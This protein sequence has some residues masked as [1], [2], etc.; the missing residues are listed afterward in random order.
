MANK[1]KLY[2]WWWSKNEQQIYE[3][4]SIEELVEYLLKARGKKIVTLQI[5]D[6]IF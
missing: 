3:E 6:S 1:D 4:I 2:S 5:P